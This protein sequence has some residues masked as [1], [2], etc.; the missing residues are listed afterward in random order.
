[1]MD[2]DTTQAGCGK[3]LTELAPGRGCG[4]TAAWEEGSL[5]PEMLAAELLAGKLSWLNLC[6]LPTEPDCDAG[7][8]V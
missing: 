2:A 8:T 6:C 1:M 5:C 4:V 3:A 7:R